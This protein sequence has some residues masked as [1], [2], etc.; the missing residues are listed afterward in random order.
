M[1]TRQRLSKCV[2]ILILVRMP[3]Q[4]K[5]TPKQKTK[6]VLTP[7]LVSAGPFLMGK[8]V[9]TAERKTQIFSDLEIQLPGIFSREI[10]I[11]GEVHKI[12]YTG[13]HS[14]VY[15]RETGNNVDDSQR[16]SGA[17]LPHVLAIKLPPTSLSIGTNLPRDKTS[18]VQSRKNM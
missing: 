18:T 1:F 16:T 12:L 8:H 5:K 10:S 17:A 9:V 11:T 3:K 14:I 2:K 4:N 13:R 7:L 6:M 15:M